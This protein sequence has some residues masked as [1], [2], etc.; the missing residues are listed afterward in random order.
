MIQEQMQEGRFDFMSACDKAFVIQMTEALAAQGYTYGDTIGDGICWGRY[1][2][3]FCKAGAKSKKVAARIYIRE[4]SVAF[5]LFLSDV[6]SHA[7]FITH[8]PP[9]I[10]EVFVGP[11]GNCKHCRGTHCQFQKSY[12]INGVKIEKCNGETFTFANAQVEQ[13]PDLIALFRAFYAPKRRPAKPS[14]E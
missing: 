8:A 3:I 7:A 1:M 14:C 6:T 9:Y 5:R 2:L 10:Q 12:E 4:D 13:I 11:Q